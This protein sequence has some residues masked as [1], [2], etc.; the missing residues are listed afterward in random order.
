LTGWDWYILK[1]FFVTFIFC[2]LL[3]TV[4]AVAGTAAKKP[5]ICKSRPHYQT[6]CYRV[7]PGFCTV[8]LGLA[9]I[10]FLC[11]LPLFFLLPKMALQSEVIA[12]LASGVTFRRWLRPYMIGG[13]LFASVLWLAN[14]Y[15]IPRANEIRSNF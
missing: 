4:I 11:S 9:C 2:M 3:F 6:D 1:K 14:R 8:Y 13:I 15:V 10:R 5:T 12:I 7:L